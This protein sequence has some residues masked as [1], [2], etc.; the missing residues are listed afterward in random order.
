METNEINKGKYSKT[1]ILKQNF[2]NRV[3]FK[4]K[5]N[6]KKTKENT[7]IVMKKKYS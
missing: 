5:H 3:F 4:S 7:I 1:K 2:L 6:K